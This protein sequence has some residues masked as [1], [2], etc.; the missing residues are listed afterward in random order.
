MWFAHMMALFAPSVSRLDA[1]PAKTSFIFGFDPEWARRNEENAA[2][3]A[4]DSSRIVLGELAD[5]VR[6]R[7]GLVSPADFSTWMNE[8]KTATG[9]KGAELFH[10][11]RIALTGAHSGPDFDKL[12]PLIEEGA[13]LRLGV[14]SVRQRVENFVGV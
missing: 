7:A 5:R 2:I 8:I 14:P 11:V 12:I 6:A 13:F 10:P 3:L 1:L 4:T 9:I